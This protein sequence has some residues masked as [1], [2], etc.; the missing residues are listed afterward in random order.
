MFDLIRR[1]FNRRLSNSKSLDDISSSKQIRAYLQRLA[2]EGS[3]E[4]QFRY[5]IFCLDG[6]GGPVNV[7]HGIYWLNQAANQGN[8]DAQYFLG[9]LLYEGRLVSKDQERANYWLSLASA[10]GNAD[11]NWYLREIRKLMNASGPILGKS[12]DI[13]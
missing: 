9:I 10:N 12:D 5:A 11:A 4:D 13:S 6:R 2:N 3:V 7:G 1:V 8:V